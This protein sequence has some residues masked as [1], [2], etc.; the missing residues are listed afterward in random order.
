M[1]KGKLFDSSAKDGVRYRR[2]S[3]LNITM[4]VATRG[5]AMSFYMLM[6]YASYIANAGYGIATILAGTIITGTRLFDGVTDPILA[7]IMDR[8][9][10][11]KHGKIRMLILIGWAISSVACVAMYNWVAG[12]FDGVAGVAM[13]IAIYAVYIIGY[14]VLNMCI[15]TINAVITNDPAQR[16]FVGVVGNIYGFGIPMLMSTL[17]AFTI[18]PK[19]NNQYNAACLKEACFWYVGVSLIL[20]IV[21]CIGIS[22]VDNAET[23]GNVV[24][25]GKK[26]EQIGFK[27]MVSLLKDNKALRMYVITGA[28]DKIA[29]Q[30]ASQSIVATMMSGILIANFK[31]S[32]MINNAGTTVGIVCGFLGAMYI[33]KFGAKKAVSVWSTIA[34]GLSVAA[35]AFCLVLGPDK[36]NEIGKVG[37]V[38][39]V[40][41]VIMIGR[42]SITTILSVAENTMKADVTDYE[43]ERSGNYMPATVSGVYFFVD[44]WI[45]SLSSTIA[46]LG[47]AMIGYTTTMPQMGDA[48]TWPIFWMTMGLM[49]VFPML[50]WICNIIAMKFYE[51]DKERM[52]EV[53]K[54]I[55]ER[56]AAVSGK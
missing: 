29:Q 15:G 31:A 13:F 38:M 16:P 20:A 49:F 32:T 48:P 56:K 39:A 4:G 36:M 43:L 25:G 2:A 53:Q 22:S 33:A 44:K 24:A 7:A 23:L 27:D 41:V 9:K 51:L 54:N 18:L 37:L 17:L 40:Y 14:T 52:V 34:V 30:T 11:G 50:G 47:A 5:V 19:Y 42:T 26:K 12:K 8:K 46:A 1:G 3:V 6:M 10:P 28:S 35:I 21:A 55:A 45:S